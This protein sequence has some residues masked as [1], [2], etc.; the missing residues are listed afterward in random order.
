[1]NDHHRLSFKLSIFSCSEIQLGPTI[2]TE[3][4][5]LEETVKE[6]QYHCH[7]K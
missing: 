5:D 3:F 4:Q 7:Y 2:D 1:M 6:K